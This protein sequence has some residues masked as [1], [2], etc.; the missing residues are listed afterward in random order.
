MVN[1][2]NGKIYKIVCNV[3]GLVY[4]G[5]TCQ[6][7]CERLR[8]HVSNYKRYLAKKYQ[9]V[10]SFDVLQNKDFYIEL[11]ESHVCNTKDE[12]HKEEAM[13]IRNTDCVNRNIPGRT[14]IQYNND[15]VEY[16]NAQNKIYRD[17]GMDKN[18][19]ERQHRHYEKHQ[20]YHQQRAIKYRLNN[21]NIIVCECGKQYKR[22]KGY[23]H[24]KTQHHIQMCNI[25]ADVQ[26]IKQKYKNYETDANI[27]LT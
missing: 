4:I 11:I 24:K 13:Y 21:S 25:I 1:Y 12:L 10:T 6:R 26:A 23:E 14:N 8:G 27:W 9:K 7:L 5:S 16:R 18:I 15:N 2:A 22:Y 17:T 19:K 20:E 3:T